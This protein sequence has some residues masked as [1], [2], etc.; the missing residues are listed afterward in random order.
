MDVV[1]VAVA[2]CLTA[3][4]R[5]VFPDADWPLLEAA[6]VARGISAR[7]AAWEDAEAD[8]AA[9]DLVVVRSTWTSVDVPQ[10][11]L[12]WVS[13]VAAATRIENAADLIAWNLDKR[14]LVELH[15]AGVPIAPTAWV[16]P[17]Q[18][19]DPPD[20]PFVVK[21]AVS[22]GGRGTAL[23]VDRP[24]LARSHVRE[25]QSAGQ[26]VMVQPYLPAVA[27]T[28]EA[29]AVFIDGRLSHATRAGPLLE[30]DIGVMERPWEKAVDV[31][32]ATPTPR[33]VEVAEA[34]MAHITRRFGV[35]LY[36][37]VDTVP[38]ELDNPVV[39]EVEFIDPFLALW[40]APTSASDLADAIARR[41]N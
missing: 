17:G 20:G 34:V 24:E 16:M 1:S 3:N 22:A 18:E 9:F 30:A 6:L 10:R 15:E 21:P 37:R 33:E 5:G 29:K 28:G 31:A 25:L 36:G 26:T 13:S 38:L 27:T 40:A 12:Q 14:H 41:L 19:W 35:P 39:L 2:G 32:I 11:Y 7:N 8:W 4:G 23:Y